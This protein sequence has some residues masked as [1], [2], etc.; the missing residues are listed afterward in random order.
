MWP[1]LR[2]R[3]QKGTQRSVILNSALVSY[4]T[5]LQAYENKK[6]FDSDVNSTETIEIFS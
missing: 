3:K 6:V 1:F 5:S 2:K 4:L